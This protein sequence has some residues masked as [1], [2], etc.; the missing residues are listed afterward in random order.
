MK[1]NRTP[2][3]FIVAIAV[4]AVITLLVW[5]FMQRRSEFAA[6]Q[7]RERPVKAS[8][9]VHFEE[10]R[11]EVKIDSS[12][13]VKSGIV[14]ET[15]PPSSHQQQFKAYGTVVS[16]QQ[17]VDAFQNYVSAKAQAAKA[18]ATAAAS[19][20]EYL[21]IKDLYG[22]RLESDKTLQ[23]AEAEWQSDDAT[24]QAAESARLSLESSI[25]QQ[26]GET[27]AR[28]VYNGSAELH[29]ILKHQHV[30]IEVTLSADEKFS[31]FP[32][33]AYVQMSTN[34]NNLL[35]AAFVS[36]AQSADSRFQGS[37]L[38]YLA[39]SSPNS[40]LGGMNV[41]VF[42]SMGEKKNGIVIPRS[43][44]VS[45]QGKTWV[46]SKKGLDTFARLELP[47]DQPLEAGWFVSNDRE[48]FSGSLKIVTH[49]AQ[50]LLSEEFRSQIQVGEEGEKK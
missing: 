15:L 3:I 18:T 25:R 17:L 4:T 50:L 45:W 41:N 5:A 32:R 10:G 29:R 12:E 9:R 19:Q 40:L 8:S 38:F 49:G 46:Y 20:K 2:K 21:R 23:T 42:L 14:T 34:E 11:A 28:W 37:I 22:K 44:A 13:Q 39:S 27:I 35:R 36:A 1:F 7:E 24:A 31:L 48:G 30:L 26:W 16:I 33:T 6:E 47:T 43:A